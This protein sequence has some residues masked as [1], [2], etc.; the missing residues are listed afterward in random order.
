[1]DCETFQ[2]FC[3]LG[4]VTMARLWR[5][6]SQLTHSAPSKAAN[7]PNL[8]LSWFRIGTVR[9]RPD[10]CRVLVACV[11]KLRLHALGTAPWTPSE[12]CFQMRMDIL[13]LKPPTLN[14]RALL[15][16]WMLETSKRKVA[17]S[18]SKVLRLRWP[19]SA[20]I[21]AY[22]LNDGTQGHNST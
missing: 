18:P 9:A 21:T 15:V 16:K 20:T 2:L 8:Y 10:V 12:Y 1:M 17:C 13:H 6:I 7:H 19:Q 3:C 4:M 5:A 22:H 11:L 14:L